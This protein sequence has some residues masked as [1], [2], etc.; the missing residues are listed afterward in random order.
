MEKNK[1]TNANASVFPVAGA[2]GHNPVRGTG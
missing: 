2:E 1:K